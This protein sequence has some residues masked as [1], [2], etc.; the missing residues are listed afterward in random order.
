LKRAAAVVA[1]TVS[2]ATLASPLRADEPAPRFDALPEASLPALPAASA[3]PKVVPHKSSVDF[4]MV[5]RNS[6]GHDFGVVVTPTPAA[7]G[8]CMS[9]PAARDGAAGGVSVVYSTVPRFLAVRSERVVVDD[10]GATL[11]VTDAW[12]D[13]KTLGA[14]EAARYEVPL[15]KLAN[16]PAGITVYGFRDGPM[17]GVVMPGADRG[18]FVRAPGVE[19]HAVACGH[20]RFALDT[21]AKGGQTAVALAQ[22]EVTAPPSTDR[23]EMRP[24]QLSVSTSRLSRDPQPVLSAAIAWADAIHAIPPP[25]VP[26]GID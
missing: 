9:A 13:A 10:H 2:A 21:S 12:I 15:G 11:L 20:I 24:L 25:F 22:I 1:L 18:G 8:T 16:G 5:V 7:Q 4:L 14:R 3:A 17:L 6:T 19:P 26:G 23:K